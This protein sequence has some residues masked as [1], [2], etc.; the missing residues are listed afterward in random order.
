ME[1]CPL[2]ATTSARDDWWWIFDPR[3]SLRARASLITGV[4]TLAFTLLATAL[5]GTLV[6]RS[7]EAQLGTHFEALAFQLA[8]K[9]DRVIHARHHDLQLMAS[10][11]PMRHGDT[12]AAERQK[13]LETVQDSARDFAWIGFADPRGT[14]RAATGGLFANTAVGTRPWFLVARERNHTAGPAELPALT[15]EL[16]PEGGTRALRYIDLAVPV[17]AA[18]GALLGALGAH[19][20]WEW[21]REVQLSVVP[22]SAR[23]ERIGVTVYS[24]AGEVLLDSGGSG[25]SQPP[26]PPVISD[27][28]KFRGTLLQSADGGTSYLTGFARSRGYREYRGL[29]WL[30]VVRQP[31]DLALAPARELQRTLFGWGALLTIVLVAVSWI[32]AARLSRRLRSVRL[33]ADR[34]RGGD[35][36]TVLPRPSGEGELARMCGSLNDLVEDLRKKSPARGSHDR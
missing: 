36:L 17:Q 4:G 3:L 33:A 26:E 30:I 23:R 28:R 22:E 19:V 21:S 35:V 11:A 29:G 5:A 9:L 13:L 27:P 34:I 7:L 25:W 20:S 8:D 14:V 15:R 32:A 31:A 16:H 6:R 10:I 1:R 18:D 12:T 2:P 24:A